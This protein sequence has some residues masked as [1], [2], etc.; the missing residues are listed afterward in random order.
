MFIVILTYSVPFGQIDALLS[1]H[2]EHVDRLVQAG[3]FVLAGR[4]VPRT[5]GIFIARGV[6]RAQLEAILADDPFISG[7]AATYEIVQFEPTR[8]AVAELVVG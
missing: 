6:D 1:A 4:R 7:G 2:Y 8:S 5:G 3:T